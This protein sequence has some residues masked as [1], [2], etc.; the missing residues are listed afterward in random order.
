MFMLC[1]NV[2]FQ[3]YCWQTIEVHRVC[4]RVDACLCIHEYFVRSL[5]FDSG[6]VGI[7]SIEF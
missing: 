3:F 4:V 2:I 6:G 1:L 5:P 7:K